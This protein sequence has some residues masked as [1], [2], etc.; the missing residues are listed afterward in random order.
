MAVIFELAL[1][2]EVDLT[3]YCMAD[4]CALCWDVMNRREAKG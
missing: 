1:T 3:V 2:G 4:A